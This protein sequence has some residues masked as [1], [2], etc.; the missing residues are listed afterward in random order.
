MFFY[1][2]YWFIEFKNSNSFFSTIRKPSMRLSIIGY[3]NL[4]LIFTT[5]TSNSRYLKHINI[6]SLFIKLDFSFNRRT[7]EGRL[8]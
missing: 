5:P 6:Y 2:V 7:N 1:Q 4:N 3:K 8:T